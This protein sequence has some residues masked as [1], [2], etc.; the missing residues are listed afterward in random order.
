MHPE[1]P[2]DP[3]DILVKGLILLIFLVVLYVFFSEGLRMVNER[4]SM[5]PPKEF[6]SYGQRS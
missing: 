2:P 5:A 3:E 1:P 4:G 6:I